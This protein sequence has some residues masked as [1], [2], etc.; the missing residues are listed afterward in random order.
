MGL[1]VGEPVGDSV[2]K[3]Q[4]KCL[5]YH[6]CRKAEGSVNSRCSFFSIGGYITYLSIFACTSVCGFLC[7]NSAFSI[8]SVNS[9]A[10]VASVNSVLSIGSI[11]CFEC[12]FNVPIQAITGQASNTCNQYSLASTPDEDNNKQSLY[13]LTYRAFE[14]A[15][16]SASEED[17]VNDCCLFIHSTEAKTQNLKGFI[18]SGTTCLVYSDENGDDN[19]EPGLSQADVDTA[20]YVYKPCPPGEVCNQPHWD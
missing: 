14:P 3:P 7:C 19:G 16:A 8:L 13:G 12:V 17:L 5:L 15:V 4:K 20:K 18:L 2:P 10:S 1:V 9:V 11:N 6:R